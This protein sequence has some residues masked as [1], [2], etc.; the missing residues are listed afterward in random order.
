MWIGL[1]K[2]TLGPTPSTLGATPSTLCVQGC[3]R[4]L[5]LSPYEPM[6]IIGLS[7]ERVS[8]EN[9]G[10]LRART[11]CTAL[12]WAR[13]CVFGS[14]G[15]VSLNCT[16]PENMGDRDGRR[17]GFGRAENSPKY[18]PFMTMKVSGSRLDKPIL[19]HFW[20]RIGSFCGSNGPN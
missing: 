14:L 16:M 8:P 15:G 6:A 4:V 19:N 10:Y 17:D 12:P 3:K 1:Q 20:V 18:A 5:T 7:L 13:N 11:A 2:G 9:T